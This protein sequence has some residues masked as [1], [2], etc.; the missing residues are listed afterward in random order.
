VGKKENRTILSVLRGFYPDLSEK[1]LQGVILCGQVKVS[2]ET[3]KDPKRIIP[4]GASPEILRDKYVSRGGLKLEKAL[5]HWNISPEGLVILD[6]GSSTGGFTDCLLKNGARIVHSVDVG[7]NQLDF[8]LRS[9]PRV[10]VHE[11][12]NIMGVKALDPEPHW[13]AADLSFRSLRK[14]AD[15]ILNL[16]GNTFLLALIKPQFEWMTPP[17]GFDG[18]VRDSGALKMILVDL[19]SDLM[20][21]GVLIDDIINSPI[22]GTHGNREFLGRIVRKGNNPEGFSIFKDI[23][24]KLV[25][26]P[27][28]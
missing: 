14:A 24:G 8:R 16:C 17:A 28:L 12:T 26:N 20:A 5:N 11:R 27:A 6:A 23:I 15:H 25:E 1:E 4:S 13:A 21:E 3:I 22:T 18:I 7:Y 2:G 10:S 19:W 9:D